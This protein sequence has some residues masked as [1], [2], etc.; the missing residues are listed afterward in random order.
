MISAGVKNVKDNLSRYLA[1]L[2][3]GEEVVI[4]ERARPIARIIKKDP[5]KK[6]IRSTLSHLVQQG[7]ITLPSTTTKWEETPMP[8]MTLSG[9]PILEMV[10][11]DRR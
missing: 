6:S 9:K 5:S 1:S 3:Q 7:S 8:T 4:T 10:V 2:K 11:E